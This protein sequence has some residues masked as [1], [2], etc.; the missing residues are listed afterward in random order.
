MRNVVRAVIIE[1]DS[2]LAIKRIKD[3]ETYW[4]FPGGGVDE[5]EDQVG[6]LVRECKE[7]L[8]VEVEVLELMFEYPFTNKKFG[9]QMEYFYKCNVIGGEFGTGDGEEYS[10]NDNGTYEPD[11]IKLSEL[12]NF[13]L[14]PSEVKNKILST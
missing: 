8:G 12:A 6:A 4:V 11:R 3:E 13:D 14:R 9:D 7:E 2:L 10:S 5:G 1:D